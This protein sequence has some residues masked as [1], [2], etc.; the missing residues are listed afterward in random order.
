M[1]GNPAMPQDCAAELLEVVPMVMRAMRAEVRGHRAPELSMP[2]FRAL[3]FIGRNEGAM[4]SD[5]ANF[6]GQSL[7]AASKLVEG[8]VVAQFAIRRQD[9]TDRRKISL[10]L[11]P[12][13]EAKH[14]AILSH[15]RAFL[16][17]KV[18][19]LGEPQRSEILSAMRSLRSI[20][21]PCQP[22]EVART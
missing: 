4:L 13:G 7:P 17:H 9:P 1:E 2:Q 21:Q 15:A 14:Q 5:V 6:L 16:S 22:M 18:E 19:H 12:S 20:F 11:S 8:L 10:K 3:A